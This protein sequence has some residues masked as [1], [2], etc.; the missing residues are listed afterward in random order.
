[1]TDPREK[2]LAELRPGAFAVAYRML[3]SVSEAEDVA[4]E[5]LLREEL[6][7]RFFA[8]TERGD[9]KTLEELLSRDVVLRGDGGGKVPALA[10]ALWGADRV[11]RALVNW[12]R[13]GG[14]AGA[15][16][17]RAR[18]NGQPGALILDRDGALIGAMSLDLGEDRVVG[19][20][21]VVNPDKLAHLGPVGDMRALLVRAK[22]AEEEGDDA[23]G[24]GLEVHRGV[25]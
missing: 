8:A 11:A 7:D 16:V 25:S 23:H 22:A 17:R 2:L 10:R 18:V 4:Q 12:G 9:M 20:N 21:S 3:G 5:A 19:V 15:S 24:V 1:L 14:R 13:Q 6:G